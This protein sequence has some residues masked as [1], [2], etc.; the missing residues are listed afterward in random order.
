M[1]TFVKKLPK[2]WKER[3]TDATARAALAINPNH[4]SLPLS[5]R[6]TLRYA[7]NIRGTKL[8]H[9]LYLIH[10][11]EN[12]E[13]TNRKASYYGI[14]NS[15]LSKPVI[16]ITLEC[17][18]SIFSIIYRKYLLSHYFFHSSLWWKKDKQVDHLSSHFSSLGQ[19]VAL[20]SA[21]RLVKQMHKDHFAHLVGY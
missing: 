11:Y 2:R 13:P 1:L 3:N 12:L 15:K 7:M 6:L 4:F 18:I 14:I 16:L 19:S 17:T 8:L 21:S 10:H 20:E 5:L 9:G